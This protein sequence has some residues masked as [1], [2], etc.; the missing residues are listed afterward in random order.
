MRASFNLPDLHHAYAVSSRTTVAHLCGY[1]YSVSVMYV[2]V[3]CPCVSISMRRRGYGSLS[4]VIIYTYCSCG[5]PE[6]ARRAG[7]ARLRHDRRAA[8]M[9]YRPCPPEMPPAP[10]AAGEIVWY[11]ALRISWPA[12]FLDERNKARREP[13]PLSH[14]PGLD[15]AEIVYSGD[16][17]R[18]QMGMRS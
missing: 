1:G 6:R 16:V 9:T 15:R 8:S 5:R 18:E 4:V 7:E 2:R 17:T 13:R 11:L 10:E 14:L 3:P 12:E